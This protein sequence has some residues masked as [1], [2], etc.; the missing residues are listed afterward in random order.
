MGVHR[1]IRLLGGEG[2]GSLKTNIEGGLPK[3]G[4]GG[5]AAWTVCQFKGGAWQEREGLCFWEG[6][7]IPNAHYEGV[8][9]ERC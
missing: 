2:V 9:W 1:K 4:G 6:G 5:G 8:L 7:L 3:K